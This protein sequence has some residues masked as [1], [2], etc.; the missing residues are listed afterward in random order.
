MDHRLLPVFGGP[1]LSF[2]DRFLRRISVSVPVTIPNELWV[3]L[4]F[5]KLKTHPCLLGPKRLAIM[6]SSDLPPSAVWVR[7]TV[8]V[9]A[10]NLVASSDPGRKETVIV[11][12]T[13]TPVALLS[14]VRGG[15]WRLFT[16]VVIVGVVTTIIS[17]LR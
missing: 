8:K 7:I 2:L 11:V 17:S 1:S 6:D 16:T 9:F 5:Y 10:H 14:V 3:L 4:G 15:F 13:A 12:V